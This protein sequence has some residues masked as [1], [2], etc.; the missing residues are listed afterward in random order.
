[1][2]V[3]FQILAD[4]CVA[5][6]FFYQSGLKNEVF[7]HIP[8][9]ET[10]IAFRIISCPYSFEQSGDGLNSFHSFKN[11]FLPFLSRAC[12]F[13][14]TNRI[15]GNGNGIF[16]AVIFLTTYRS[17]SNNSSHKAIGRTGKP[18]YFPLA[19]IKALT[20]ENPTFP[21]RLFNSRVVYSFK[22]KPVAN[23][24]K[25]FETCLDPLTD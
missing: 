25:Y 18:I 22:W 5:I 1:M 23:S 13:T 3:N 24:S 19:P 17:L 9:R 14:P 8:F 20:R 16:L 12:Y 21:N 11:T 6:T 2:T 4:V 10:T 7:R 15:S